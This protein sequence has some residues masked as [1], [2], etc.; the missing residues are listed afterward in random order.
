MCGSGGGEGDGQMIFYVKR[1]G[2]LRNYF[3]N[4]AG[5]GGAGA[6]AALIFS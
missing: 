6:V 4:R 5:C 1:S 2:K 3:L